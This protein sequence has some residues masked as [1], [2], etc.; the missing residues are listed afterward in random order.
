MSVFT[1]QV[2][3]LCTVYLPDGH[4][5]QFTFQV[6]ILYTVY[7]SGGH[8]VYILPFRWTLWIQF[9]FQVDTLYNL[10]YLVFL[11]FNIIILHSVEF[12]EDYV[13]ASYVYLTLIEPESIPRQYAGM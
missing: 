8:S 12:W 11:F 10:S 1:S 7:L 9:T 6:D 3:T 5:I 2:D 13:Y 4:C